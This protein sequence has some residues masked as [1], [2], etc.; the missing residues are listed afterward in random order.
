MLEK[1][2]LIK[3]IQKED[4]ENILA[5]LNEPYMVGREEQQKKYFNRCFDENMTKERV[6]FVAY[7]DDEVVGYV[8]IIFKSAYPY[9]NQRNI[10]EINDLYVVPAYRKNGIGKLLIDECEKY[11]SG[12]YE[13]IGLGVG[14]YKDY[15]SA[16][17]LYIKNWYIFDGNGLMYNNVSV[18]PGTKVHVDDELLLYLH[19]RIR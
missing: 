17:R 15:G 11:A 14:L 10:P 5:V 2:I 3:V 1:K 9:F 19:K 8:N 6:T 7:L 4:I 18:D 13:Y 16:Q 12:A